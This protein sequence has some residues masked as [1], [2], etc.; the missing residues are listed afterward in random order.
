MSAPDGIEI[1]DLQRRLESAFADER[2]AKD[3]NDYRVATRRW[4]KLKEE[5]C[6][7]SAFLSFIGAGGSAR[8]PLDSLVP[9]AWY[10]PVGEEPVGIEV[11]LALGRTS[12]ELGREMVRDGVGRG[13]LGLQDNASKDDFDR[14]LQRPRVM[15]NTRQALDTVGTGIRRC[16]EAKNDCKYQGMWLLVLAPLGILPRERWE[17]IESDLRQYA[18]PMPFDQIH[19]FDGRGQSARGFQI[20]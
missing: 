12:Y 4:K 11:T 2:D 18:A 1:G 7:V 20:K 17:A 10:T 14:A 5:V 13:F 16:L 3:V 19:V 9:D 6:P 8:F 15:Y